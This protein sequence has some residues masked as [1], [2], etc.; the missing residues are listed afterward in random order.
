ME[1]KMI[2]TT[3]NNC[4]NLSREKASGLD[5]WRE[6]TVFLLVFLRGSGLMHA[7]DSS[8]AYMSCRMLAFRHRHGC[9]AIGWHNRSAEVFGL[10]SD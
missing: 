7:S 1:M 8:W 10:K 5:C 4:L 2:M 3:S 9:S 6:K